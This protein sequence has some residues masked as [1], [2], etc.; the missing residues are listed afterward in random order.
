MASSTAGQVVTCK[1]MV[2]WEN[3]GDLIE[4]TI[5]VDPPKRGEVRI[6]ILGCGVCHTDW[7]EPRAYPSSHTP[8]GSD[9]PGFPVILG[10]E[11]GGIVESVGE[12]VTSLSPGDYCVPLYVPECRACRVCVSQKNNGCTATE[13]TQGLGLMLD[14]TTRFSCVKNGTKRE[15]LHFMG[16]SAFAE[17][18][19]VNEINCAKIS[20]DAPLEKVCLLGCGV[21]TGHGA[22]LNTCKVEPGSTAAVYGLGGVGLSVVSALKYV[23]ASRIIGVDTNPTKEE[24]ASAQQ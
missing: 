17:Y 1:A 3:G 10:H 11:G 9:R 23:G 20:K 19:V 5:Q 4:E 12:G 18:T 15:I 7:S 16:V 2:Q 8:A 14:G 6:K 21:T 22:V 24:Q 13:D